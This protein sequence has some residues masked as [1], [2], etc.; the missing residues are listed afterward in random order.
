[1]LSKPSLE[2][3]DSKKGDHSFVAYRFATSQFRF[4][5]HYHPEYELTLILKGNGMRLIG[6]SYEPFA[7]GDLVLI[8]PNLPHSWTSELGREKQECVVVQFSESFVN[9]LLNC[10]EFAQ[11]KKMLNVSRQSIHFAMVDDVAN[12][13][14]TLPE[15]KGFE[16]VTSLLSILNKLT[17][18]QKQVLAS[19][20]F[21]PIP[22]K[23][24]QDRVNRIFN[25]VHTHSSENISISQLSSMINLSD[26]AFCKFFK[27]TSGKTFSDY[28]ND[29]RIGHAC[30]LLSETERSV[31]EI[32]YSVGFESLTYFN[33]VFLR[34]KGKSPKRFRR[35]ALFS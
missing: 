4:N 7:S 27:R 1:M 18:L 17:P 23:M 24:D 3:I 9:G 33:R 31:S 15:K 28:L 11:I 6:D 29:V 32:A 34:K 5:W 10:N 30:K 14:L 16:R 26:S 12:D 25:F 2:N 22:Q 20:F 13:I 19:E 35:L 21:K 8:G